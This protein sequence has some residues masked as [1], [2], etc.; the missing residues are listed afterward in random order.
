M[1]RESHFLKVYSI[2]PT[3]DDQPALYEIKLETP[4][5]AFWYDDATLFISTP[6]SKNRA[7]SLYACYIYSDTRFQ[8]PVVT[9][10]AE[11]GELIGTLPT[12]SAGNLHYSSTK[13]ALVFTANVF[14]DG[15]LATAVSQE[16][17]WNERKDTAR[18]YDGQK[19]IRHFNHYC[20]P[21]HSSLFSTSLSV[22]EGK[23]KFGD[24]CT[25]LLKGT[26]HVRASFSSFDI[27]SHC[28]FHLP[29]SSP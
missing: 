29:E 7:T 8:R 22:Q 16:R 6:D 20:G 4:V 17:A 27:F 19:Y 3:A 12:D 23:W 28:R 11:V 10:V 1:L 15:A 18:A 24:V 21:M 5:A 2:S 25:N 9:T 14:A 13:H 26:L